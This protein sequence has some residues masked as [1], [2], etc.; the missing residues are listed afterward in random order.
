MIGYVI[1]TRNHVIQHENSRVRPYHAVITSHACEDII[2]AILYTK[3]SNA[4]ADIIP[5]NT[6]AKTCQQPRSNISLMYSCLFN[7]AW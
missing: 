4:V 5:N 3:L 7:V 6:T 1:L 2:L